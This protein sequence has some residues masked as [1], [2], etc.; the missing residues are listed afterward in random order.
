MDTTETYI[1]MRLAAIPDLG[2]GHPPSVHSHQCQPYLTDNIWVAENGDFY[3][4]TKS[5]TCQLE[6]QD[7]LQE[8]VDIKL[9]SIIDQFHE[10]TFSVYGHIVY[11]ETQRILR[12]ASLEQLWLAFCMSEKYGKLWR[13]TEWIKK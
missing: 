2:M 12:F 5:L 10:F 11:T 8:M 9:S 13:G 7:Q 3:Y 4:F 1:K 6:R